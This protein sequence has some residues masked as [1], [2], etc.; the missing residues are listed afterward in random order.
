MVKKTAFLCGVFFFAFFVAARADSLSSHKR[1]EA[2]FHFHSTYSFLGETSIEEIATLA[3]QRGM[4]AI[5]LTDDALV[6]IT[7][8]VP[9]FRNIF[10]VTFEKN[11]IYHL[12]LWRYLDEIAKVQKKVPSVLLFPGM[13]VSAFHYWQGFPPRG[14]TVRDWNKHM[15][16]FGFR[17]ED[18]FRHLPILGNGLAFYR[19]FD[20]RDLWRLW[21]I[22]PVLFGILMIRMPFSSWRKGGFVVIGIG[23]LGLLDQFPFR[24]PIADPYSGKTAVKPYQAV[25]DYTNAHG[26]S[27]FW[28]HPEAA[29]IPHKSGPVSLLTDPYPEMLLR[30]H[31]YTGFSVFYE[32]WDILA[33]PGGPWDQVLLEYCRGIRHKPAWAI[34]ELDFQ[35]E[36][37]ADVWIG[38]VKTVLFVEEKTPSAMLEAIRLGRMYAV[39]RSPEAELRLDHFEAIDAEGNPLAEMGM[40]VMI[41]PP[42]RIHL[43]ISR[44]DGKEGTIRY[45]LVR[46]GEVLKEGNVALPFEVTIEE[47]IPI[48]QKSY[49]RLMVEGDQGNFLIT[50]PIFVTGKR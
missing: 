25:I 12:G 30:T 42:I 10:R 28:A 38:N 32:G 40:D 29:L 13:E 41:P 21:G 15:I 7:Y 26:G 16:V 27:V 9:P 50:N 5:F 36:G 14:A 31:D 24:S 4:D 23:L 43:G 48:G 33:Q 34:G 8:G 45:R 11:S 2:A 22:V 47:E 44:S 46:N 39:R 49:Y 37:R 35:K 6:K 3:A 20:L 19:P 18:D 17:K 1:V